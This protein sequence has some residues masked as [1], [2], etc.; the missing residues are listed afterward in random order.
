M[1]ENQKE[2]PTG[3]TVWTGEWL[4]HL[5]D[6]NESKYGKDPA[7]TIDSFHSGFHPKAVRKAG[8]QSNQDVM[9]FHVG[10]VP[11]ALSAYVSDQTIELDG[12]L[13][14]EQGR[15]TLLQEE[16]IKAMAEEYGETI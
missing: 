5:L 13:F 15:S 16:D 3:N 8:Q 4:Q 2:D 14:W 10:R 6:V 1:R 12:D 11:S 7:Y 9:H